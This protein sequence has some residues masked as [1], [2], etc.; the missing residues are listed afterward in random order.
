M[1]AAAALPRSVR[2]TRVARRSVGWGPRDQPG[3]FQGVDQVGHIAGRAPQG[4][5]ELALGHRAA[6]AEAPEQL[7][8]GAA[9]AA[10]GQAALHPI[11]EQ[12]GELEQALE[13]DTAAIY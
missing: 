2:L 9:E 8:A 13:R 4:L 5:A 7:G 11:G 6:R 3:A 10:L 12:Q 1:R